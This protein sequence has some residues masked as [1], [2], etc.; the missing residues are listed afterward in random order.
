MCWFKKPKKTK[1]YLE[2]ESLINEANQNKLKI[3][4]KRFA[5]KKN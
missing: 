4:H 5:D 2:I 1:F 3:I